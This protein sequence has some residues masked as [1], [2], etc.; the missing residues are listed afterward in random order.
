MPYDRPVIAQEPGGQDASFDG[1]RQL[2]AWASSQGK[3]LHVV[4][5]HGMCSHDDRW[6]TDRVTR[7]TTALGGSAQFAGTSDEP[8]KLAR[9][10]YEF[11]TPAGRFDATFILWS[12]LTKP[13]KKQLASDTP[14]TDPNSSFPYKRASFNNDLKVGLMNDC[15]ADA[16]VYAGTNGDPIREQMKNAICYALGGKPGAERQCDLTGADLDRPLAIVTES[17]GSKFLFDAVRA[18]WV[19]ASGNTAQ[20]EP[21][22]HRLASVGMVYLIANQ[23]PLLDIASPLSSSNVST[24]ESAASGP[25]PIPPQASSLKSFLDVLS[26]ARAS[27]SGPGLIEAPTAV[28]VVAFSDSNDLLTYR[29]LANE[30]DVPKA[31]LVD[32]ITSND[33]TWF[34]FVER[35]DYAHCG[36]AW[37]RQVI[38]LLVNGHT[39]GKPSL[40]APALPSGECL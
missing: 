13:F 30:L 11:Q 37:N 19:D 9:Y 32:V 24:P 6:L 5:T 14:G 23:I 26:Q 20:Q 34:D 25:A 17:L 35:P 8:G 4:W 16:V 40:E 33:E 39:V 15:L 21:L 31:T 27:R 2:V 12:P 7:V 18:V 28:T 38:G 36:Y 3:T 10:A 22:A 29:L 1:I